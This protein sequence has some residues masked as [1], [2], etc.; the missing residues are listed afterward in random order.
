MKTQTPQ[1][2]I[3]TDRD[4]T[5]LAIGERSVHLTNLRKTFFSEIDVT[6]CV[7]QIFFVYCVRRS[8]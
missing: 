5:V 1:V 3:P 6:K 7:E 8:C 2:T 4:E